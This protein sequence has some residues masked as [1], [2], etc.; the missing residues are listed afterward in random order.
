MSV[1]AVLK[2]QTT[3][4]DAKRTTSLITGDAAYPTGGHTLLPGALGFGSRIQDIIRGDAANLAGGAF[5]PIFTPTYD[6]SGDGSIS[7]IQFQLEQYTT[8]L[9]V[10]AGT[11]VSAAGYYLLVEGN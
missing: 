1:S 5:V 9:E 10:A 2:S 8:A 3:R 6:A 4:G 11:N 7:A